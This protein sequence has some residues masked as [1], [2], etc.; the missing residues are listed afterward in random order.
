LAF[1]LVGLCLPPGAQARLGEY[2]TWGD[3]CYADA[4]TNCVPDC[5]F[6][7]VA[8]WEV[9]ALR[10]TPPEAL[11]R[12]AFFNA[13]GSATAGIDPDHAA[14]YLRRHGFGGVRLKVRAYWEPARR[15]VGR[16]V[17]LYHAVLAG[18]WSDHEITVIGAAAK[19]LTYITYGETRHMSWRE[20]AEE[21]AEVWTLSVMGSSHPRWDLRGDRRRSTGHPGRRR[22]TAGVRAD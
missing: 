2:P 1:L 8:D 4:P 11:V 17:N 19:G 10:Y 3:L 14:R 7:S 6:A 13:G 22:S 21:G 18:L 20:W 12:R 9:V 15:R 16:L 5:V